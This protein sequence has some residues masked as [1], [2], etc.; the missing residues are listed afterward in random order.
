MTLASRLFH[1]GVIAAKLGAVGLLTGLAFKQG[2]VSFIRERPRV[3]LGECILMGMSAAVPAMAM[4]YTRRGSKLDMSKTITAVS[5]AFMLF[6]I[7]HLLME[8][9]GMN[10]ADTS[11][12][13]TADKAQQEYLHK[14]VLTK[15][16]FLTMVAAGLMMTWLAGSAHKANQ[17]NLFNSK[18]FGAAIGEMVL[19]GVANGY[20]YYRILKA[21][22][23]RK[24]TFGKAARVGLLFSFG[25]MV[26]EMGGFFTHVFAHE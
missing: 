8:F 4:A 22:G 7:F 15:E 3:F 14:H 2:D 24:G 26:L 17:K 23:D 25:Y 11:E 5:L 20:P 1:G 13:N 18:R 9:S 6:F 21:R 19:F 12:F 10:N 16:T